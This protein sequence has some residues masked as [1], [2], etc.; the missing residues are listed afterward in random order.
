[1]ILGYRSCSF[2]PLTQRSGMPSGLQSRPFN[3]YI[4]SHCLHLLDLGYGFKREELATGSYQ[5]KMAT[6]ESPRLFR[7]T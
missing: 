5:T 2:S 4:D 7:D 6:G 1:M 3:L